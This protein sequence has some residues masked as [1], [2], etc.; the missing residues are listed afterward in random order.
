M[1]LRANNHKKGFHQSLEELIDAKEWQKIQ[2]NFSAITSVGIRVLNTSCS[3]VI[4]PSGRPR[5][6]TEL[7]NRDPD[8]LKEVCGDCLPTFLGGRWSVD[9]NI[10]YSCH[11]SDLCNFISP[12]KVE[13]MVVGYI[14]IGPVILVMRKTKEQYAK[15]AEELGLSVEDFW[16]AISEIKVISFSGAQALVELVKDVYEYLL[17]VTYQ[18]LM[19]RKELL[20]ID[21]PKTAKLLNALLDVAFQVSGADV[22][23]IMFLDKDKREL[24][25]KA[26]RGLSED[27][28]HNARVKLGEGISGRAAKEGEAFIIDDTLK[29]NRI[30][31]YLNRPYINSSMVVPL[32]VE[33]S[34]IGVMN[35]GAV[36]SA[37]RFDT[38]SLQLMNKLTDLATVALHE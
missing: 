18:N 4:K 33:D 27:V 36:T 17:R 26:S 5:L 29:D 24:F 16:S 2:D 13:N 12:L 34:V 6:C 19:M 37:A 30:K 35:L 10:S 8:K 31:S 9:K 14:L 28:V 15:V 1:F 23:S 25:I 32:K 21:S 22:G 7:L 38:R 11:H 3:P 20:V